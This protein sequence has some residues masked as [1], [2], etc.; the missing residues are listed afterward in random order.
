MENFDSIVAENYA[1]TKKNEELEKK[2]AE[3]NHAKVNTLRAMI[4]YQGGDGDQILGNV[5]SWI[6]KTTAK[7]RDFFESEQAQATPQEF[8]EAMQWVWKCLPQRPAETIKSYVDSQAQKI[9][10]LN[11]VGS[12]TLLA[13]IEAQETIAEQAKEIERLK[14]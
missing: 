1:L 4:Q 7:Y 14:L 3:L 2:I 5:K 8:H 9:A 11:R 10:D 13:L 12:N 6:T